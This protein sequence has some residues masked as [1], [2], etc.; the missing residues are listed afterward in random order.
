MLG[1]GS[2]FGGLLL[3][4]LL[5]KLAKL[6]LFCLGAALGAVVGCESLFSAQ[7]RVVCPRM[8]RARSRK[9]KSAVG[10]PIAWAFVRCK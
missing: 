5:L 8:R 10:G 4:L 7:A 1:F 3:G 6:A 9:L 2:L